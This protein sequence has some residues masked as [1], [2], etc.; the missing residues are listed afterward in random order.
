MS[1]VGKRVIYVGGAGGNNSTPLHVEGS[2]ADAAA[3]GS[4]MALSNTGLALSSAAATAFGI[5]PLFADKDQMRGRSVDDPWTAGENMVAI[6][7]RSGEFLNVL[8]A[9]GQD[10][11]VGT[12]LV[13]DGNG[14]LTAGT[15]AG[16]QNALAIS[17]ED[18]TT[19]GVT[20]VRVR[21]V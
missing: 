17:D 3:A 18:I 4:L 7:G 21:I 14:V 8:V 12:P 13:S 11:D 16:T 2:A 20:L 6:Q 10:L 15:G 9:D 1:D 5:L 19:S